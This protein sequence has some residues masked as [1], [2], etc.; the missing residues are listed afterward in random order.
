MEWTGQYEEPDEDNPSARAEAIEA[1]Q[2]LRGFH[3]LEY[4]LFKNGA[5]RT[6]K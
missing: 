6:V 2:S 3:T 1:A 5:P 4:L